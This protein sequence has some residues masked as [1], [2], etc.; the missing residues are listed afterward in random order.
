MGQYVRSFD[1]ELYPNNFLLSGLDFLHFPRVEQELLTIPSHLTSLPVFSGICVVFC[2]SLFVC[3][4]FF[5]WP[6]CCLSLALRILIAFLQS[7]SCSYICHDIK[8]EQQGY[9][10][11]PTICTISIQMIFLETMLITVLLLQNIFDEQI[12]LRIY[13][14][15]WHIP[16]SPLHINDISTTSL[17]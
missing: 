12:R 5:A 1:V 10:D 13:H 7:S 15:N 14:L 16:V 6:L 8:A 2:Q 9:N 17:V 3:L 11:L 4:S